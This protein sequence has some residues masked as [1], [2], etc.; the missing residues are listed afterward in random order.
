MSFVSIRTL[1]AASFFVSGSLISAV[2]SGAPLLQQISPTPTT[3]QQNVD[4]Q[5]FTGSGVTYASFLG[6]VTAPL[7]LV[8]DLGCDSTDFAGF[9][10]GNI[11]LI[12]RG[13][14]EFDDKVNNADV[15]GA[16]GALIY[17]NLSGLVG[18]GGGSA[19]QRDVHSIA[20][21]YRYVGGGLGRRPAPRRSRNASEQCP[22]TRHPRTS[23]PGPR[24]SRSEPTTQ[25]ELS[26][27]SSAKQEARPSDGLS[28]FADD[29]RC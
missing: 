3:Y 16:V 17:N 22:R 12:L 7:Q 6:D 11:A 5:F 21:Y 8:P 27:S 25:G 10:A 13:T 23:R 4:Y 2:A 28:L 9:T 29:V 1:L 14:C 24:R 15:A 18:G 19:S 26:V 20:V